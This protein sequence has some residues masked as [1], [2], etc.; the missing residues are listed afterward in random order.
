MIKIWFLK[1]FDGWLRII[2][3]LLSKKKQRRIETP[4]SI[5]FIK[6]SAMGDALCLMPA[7]RMLS[8][9][10]PDSKIDWVTTSRSQPKM[11]SNIP[12]LNRIEVISLNHVSLIYDIVV[13]IRK[14]KSY[15]IIIDYDQ[16]YSIS[17]ILAYLGKNNAGFNAP[18]KG[19]TYDIQELYQ[20]F[21][22]EKLQFLALTE[23]IIKYYGVDVPPYSPLLTELLL[24]FKPSV[25]LLTE[26]DKLRSSGKPVIIIYP[27]SS[28][29]ASFRRWGLEN[30]IC[31]IKQLQN[32]CKIVIAGGPDEI[33]MKPQFI[34]DEIKVS[35]WIGKWNLIEW[36]WI[37][38]NISNL[39]V[40]NDGG[41]FHLADLMGLCSV[42]IFGPALYE[43]WG[44]IN[45]TSSGVEINLDCRP[46]L[47][48]Y[49]G[50]V[51]QVCKRGD[52]ACLNS[53]DVHSVV[54]Q[55]EQKLSYKYMSEKNEL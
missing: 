11:F 45:K 32:K 26:A 29:N 41:L 43:K 40:G 49:L 38:R 17:E 24:D 16:Y 51:P 14:L 19:K 7:I 48:N 34:S 5:M 21:R 35:D 44:S 36:A 10:F 2:V 8:I 31:I 52:L 1:Q 47:K 25:K 20:P 18:L 23:K 54:Y 4:S 30:Y 37:F 9:A 28:G 53:I 13:L 12:Y 39:F 55:V 42:T 33:E 46:C 15:D 22:N 3:K 6:L 50:D 27:G